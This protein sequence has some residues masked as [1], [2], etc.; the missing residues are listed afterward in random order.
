MYDVID[1]DIVKCYNYIIGEYYMPKGIYERTSEHA[2]NLSNALL[3]YWEDPNSH[4]LASEAQKR[5]NG[6]KYERTP[7]HL[8][9]LRDGQLKRWADPEEVERAR[10]TSLRVLSDP[11][12][13]KALSEAQL[14]RWSNSKEYVKMV[15]AHIERWKNPE[16]RKR[17][18]DTQTERYQDPEEGRKTSEAMKKFWNSLTDEEKNERIGHLIKQKNGPT[19]PEVALREYLSSRGLSKWKYN[20]CVSTDQEVRIGGRV[21]DFI[22]ETEKS[23]ISAMGGLNYFHFFEDEE[24][25]IIHYRSRGYNCKVI[26]EYDCYDWEGLD[27]M[28]QVGLKGG[29]ICQ[30]LLLLE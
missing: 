16:L 4:K 6:G 9:A 11:E 12:V 17:V 8:R 10:K 3:R 5:G 24:D 22:N 19:G 25:E 13:R 29:S 20:G 28:F 14:R 15:E 27:K 2:R 30:G 7:E 21:P 26:W 18:S 23:V 1:N